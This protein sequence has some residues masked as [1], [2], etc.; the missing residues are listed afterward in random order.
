MAALALCN[1]PHSVWGV[2]FSLQLCKSTSYLS[3]CLSL[4]YV[5]RHQEPEFHQ[6][7]KQALWVLAGFESQSDI[8]GLRGRRKL[9]SGEWR[10]T[11]G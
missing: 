2:Y 11:W 10:G 5:V 1:G 6:V 3:L 4:N 8:N 9:E 7:L